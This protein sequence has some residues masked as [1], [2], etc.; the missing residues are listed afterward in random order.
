MTF[1]FHYVYGRSVLVV[2]AFSAGYAM[3]ALCCLLVSLFRGCFYE[4][5]VGVLKY[6]HLRFRFEH[7]FWK[8]IID[9]HYFEGLVV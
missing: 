5:F 8:F 9:L 7:L 4:V 2:L 1:G 3:P 6:Q